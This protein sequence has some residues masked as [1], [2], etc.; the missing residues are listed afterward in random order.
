MDR[1]FPAA[2]LLS[3]GYAVA[4]K[5]PLGAKQGTQNNRKLQ[6]P[7]LC[8]WSKRSGVND[9]ALVMIMAGEHKD[10]QRD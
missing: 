2:N 9:C 7:Y 5:V 4:L 10:L 6:F 1:D 8:Y 3:Q